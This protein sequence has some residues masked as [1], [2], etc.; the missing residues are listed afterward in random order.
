MLAGINAIS[1]ASVGCST[2]CHSHR[3]TTKPRTLKR[4]PTLRHQLLQQLGLSD[5]ES[6]AAVA[7]IADWV[8]RLHPDSSLL[9]LS[10]LQAAGQTCDGTL[11]ADSSS[12]SPQRLLLGWL[13]TIGGDD[14]D[15][16][17]RLPAAG[18]L[19][20]SDGARSTL[21]C[22]V[23][24]DAVPAPELRG[25]LVLA[26]AWRY[27]PPSHGGATRR[28]SA[29]GLGGRFELDGHLV[30][31][32]G[33]RQPLPP[34]LPLPAWPSRAFGDGG[35]ARRGGT[36]RRRRPFSAVLEKVALQLAPTRCRAPA[37]SGC[38]AGKR[39]QPGDDAAASSRAGRGAGRAAPG[40]AAL[41]HVVGCA[42]SVSELVL[43][44]AGAV[45]AASRLPLGC[46]S[47]ASRLPLGCLSAASR[48]GFVT[49]VLGCISE[50]VSARRRGR[51]AYAAERRAGERDE[52]RAAA[53]ASSSTR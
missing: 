31:C 26:T 33:P 45:S 10:K 1:F 27:V 13:G 52:R 2:N 25:C 46:L 3:S 18:M 5:A 40:S 15:A 7:A 24:A 32:L 16:F 43:L 34:R 47:A 20:L 19:S 4:M 38:G 36:R 14:G 53:H 11:G 21:P 9:S 42:V 35:S 12:S 50:F 17:D 41:L 22:S 37:Q 6:R 48:T 28:R 39:K 8:C 49:A 30:R 44:G 23:V 51:P 29:G